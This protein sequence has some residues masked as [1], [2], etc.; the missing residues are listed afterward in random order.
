MG[1]LGL[2]RA[3]LSRATRFAPLAVFLIPPEFFLENGIHNVIGAALNEPGVIVD[4]FADGGLDVE[5]PSHDSVLLLDQ[6]HV[7]PPK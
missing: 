3:G 7:G 1:G 2:V 6:W 4:E 5:L